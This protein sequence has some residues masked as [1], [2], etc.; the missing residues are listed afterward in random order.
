MSIVVILLSVGLMVFMALATA[1]QRTLRALDLRRAPGPDSSVEARARAMIL[2]GIGLRWINAAFLLA[3]SVYLVVARASAWYHGVTIVA[4][5]W[6]G[7]LLMR[8]MARLQP[9]GAKMVAFV[10]ADLKRRREWYRAAN[11]TAYLAAVEE[12]LVSVRSISEIQAAAGL[13]R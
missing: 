7:S 9:G 10:V 11:D 4:L 13:H 6:I 8:G 5:C 1:V 3:V 12:L 2:L